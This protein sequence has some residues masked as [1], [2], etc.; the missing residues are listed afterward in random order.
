M[1]IIC[2]RELKG[3][4]YSPQAYI[5][6]GFF[7]L[8]TGF[9]FSDFVIRASSPNVQYAMSSWPIIFLFIAPMLTMK[10]FTEEKK[11]GTEKLIFSSP[12]SVE[13]VVLGKFFSACLVYLIALGFTLIHVIIVFMLGKPDIGIVFSSYLGNI[14]LG[15]S[16]LSV[17]IFASSL[18]ENQ[19]IAGVISFGM[20]LFFW[21][22]DLMQNMFS[23]VSKEFI[24]VLSLFEPYAPFQNGIVSLS[25]IIYYLSFTGIFLFLT[26]RVI[27]SRWLQ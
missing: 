9:L 17:G 26:I 22:A 16:F 10:L 18:T 25:G 27:K 14:L 5:L 4:F 6:M 11:N 19:I 13:M 21:L 15:F 8:L 3:Y 7:L 23:G 2:K 24:K 12:V 20:L 1:W